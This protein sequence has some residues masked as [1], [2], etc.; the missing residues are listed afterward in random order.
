MMLFKLKRSSNTRK[1]HKKK[2]WV[3]VAD[4]EKTHNDDYYNGI[5]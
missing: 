3:N 5:I 1:K 2:K 4:L